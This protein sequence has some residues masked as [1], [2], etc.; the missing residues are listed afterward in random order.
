MPDRVVR[1]F[2]WVQCIPTHPIRPLEHRR[3]ANNRV[4]MVKNV[5]IYALWLEA[6]SHLLMST[7]TN[8]PALPLSRCTDDYMPWFLPR[9]HPRIQNPERFPRSIQLLTTTP[10]TLKVLVDMISLEVD[11]DDIDDATRIGRISDMIKNYNQPRLLLL[12]G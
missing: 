4:Y 7:W 6:L 11:R 1:Q 2:G 3:L 5:F 10:I 9:T 8:V 12:L